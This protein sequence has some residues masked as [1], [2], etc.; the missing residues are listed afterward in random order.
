[1]LDKFGQINSPTAAGDSNVGTTQSRQRW[2]TGKTYPD[3]LT[4]KEIPP[5]F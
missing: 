1:M 5:D 4:G 3:D 2:E